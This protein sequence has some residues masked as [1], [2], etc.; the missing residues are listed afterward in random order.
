MLGIGYSSLSQVVTHQAA[1]YNIEPVKGVSL[2][3]SI[4]TNVISGISTNILKCRLV[5]ES[6]N[7]I[8]GLKC[9]FVIGFE[10]ANGGQDYRLPVFESPEMKPITRQTM[11]YTIYKKLK[12][13]QT[14]EWDV[15]FSV[16]HP[17]DL[18]QIPERDVTNANAK[19]YYDNLN[20]MR[21]V[22][23]PGNYQIRI[24]EFPIIVP[25]EYGGVGI[26]TLGSNFLEIKVAE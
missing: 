13:G 11:P 18:A 26:Y 1:S 5:N 25:D 23:I 14:C 24:N 15:Y 22:K 8:K 7:T 16:S 17:L 10:N 2:S 20:S 12:P 21:L 4:E 9:F 3:I 6:T 19:V